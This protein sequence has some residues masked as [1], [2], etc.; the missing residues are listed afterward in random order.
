LWN[1]N[2]LIIRSWKIFVFFSC[3]IQ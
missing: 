3:S 1:K 2:Q